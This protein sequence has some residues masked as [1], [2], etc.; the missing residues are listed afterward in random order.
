MLQN[1]PRILLADDHRILMDALATVLREQFE[2]VATFSDGH[3]LL[4][5]MRTH[6]VEAVVLDISMPGLNGIEA[7]KRISGRYPSTAVVFLTMHSERAYVEEALRAGALGYVLKREAASELVRAVQSA[8]S[9]K[10]YISASSWQPSVAGVPPLRDVLT[11]R[12]RDVLQLIS[13]GRSSKEIAAALDISVR[14][15]EFHRAQLMD[16]LGLRTTAE[17]TRWAIEH[18]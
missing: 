18:P 1:R 14:T 11:E 13:E 15:V 10:L 4:A 7:A 6:A 3:E 8:L 16:R 12:Q 5:G 9:G 2:I 17:L